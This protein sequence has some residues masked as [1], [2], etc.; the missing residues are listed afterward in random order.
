MKALVS[1]IISNFKILLF[2]TASLCIIGACQAREVITVYTPYSAGHGGNVAFQR[3]LE[4]ANLNQ[5]SYT[6]VLENR[7]GAQGVIALQAMSEDPNK[8][9][10]IIHAAFVDN[11]DAGQV[12]EH[13][14]RPVHGIGDACW[15]VVSLYGKNNSIQSLRGSGELTVGTVG[16]GNVTHLTA[17]AIADRLQLKTRLVIFKSNYDAVVNLAGNHG[18]TFGIE[19]VAVVQQLQQINPNIRMLAMSCS[20]RLAG[21][22]ELPT[23][24]E[25]GIKTP[26]V[27]NIVVSNQRMPAEKSKN[28]GAILD[29]ATR[30]V[31]LAE[32][33]RLGDMRSPVFDNMPVEKFY[34]ERVAQIRSLRAKYQQEIQ[35]SKNQ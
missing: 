32:I 28:I 30:G 24:A 31:G 34:R 33:Q 12:K 23:L 20:T 13:D 11:I 2:W 8:K 27:F 26:S 4:Q 5:T 19:R 15:A 14:Y 29:Q 25:Q 17:L 18:V 9:L 10:A 16:H 3:V 7:P 1:I 21:T 6:F 35:Q 22:P